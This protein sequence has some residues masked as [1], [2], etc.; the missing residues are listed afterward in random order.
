LRPNENST[1][2]LGIS[3]E[4]PK[5]LGL[6]RLEFDAWEDKIA[7]M[8]DRLVRTP[9]AGKAKLLDHVL[10][11]IRRKHYSICIEQA[12]RVSAVKRGLS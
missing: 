1:Q 5:F 4:T 3:R 2:N 12:L 8:A 11:G 6:I 9:A 7:V 10:N